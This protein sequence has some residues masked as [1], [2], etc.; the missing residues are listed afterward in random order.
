[1]S[2]IPDWAFGVPVHDHV[3][4][5]RL[6]VGDYS[7]RTVNVKVKSAPF[8]RVLYLSETRTRC[9]RVALLSY[10]SDDRRRELV[11]VQSLPSSLFRSCASTVCCTVMG[12]RG[13]VVVVFFD[14]YNRATRELMREVR[15]CVCADMC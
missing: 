13:N 15:L 14:S 3:H 6:K 5:S 7:G 8:L 10:S 9:I 2:S 1:M 4:V 11:K 12:L